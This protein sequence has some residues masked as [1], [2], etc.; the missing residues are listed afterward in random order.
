MTT[1]EKAI[2]LAKKILLQPSS[3]KKLLDYE[4]IYQRHIDE[5]YHISQLPSIDIRSILPNF[6]ETIHKYTFLEGTSLVIDI[7]LLKALARHFENCHYLEL[8]SWRGESL[9]NVAEVSEQCVSISLSDAQL[10]SKGFDDI[11][12]S[13]NGLFS[14]SLPNVIQIAED[15]R[16]FDFKNFNQKFDLIFIDADHSYEGVK[17]DTHNVLSLLKNEN[18]IVVWHDY[19]YSTEKVRSPVLAGILDGLPDDTAR[20][21]VFHV[22]NTMCAIYR[23][24]PFENAVMQQPFM[25]NKSFSVEISVKDL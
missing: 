17:S 19:G 2:L 7:A 12:I 6:S 11:F 15:T 10:K 13:L 5:K 14:K 20:Q 4:T 24:K 3:L 1:L 16:A 25:P 9:V 18:S 23:Q 22:S 8:G 21:N